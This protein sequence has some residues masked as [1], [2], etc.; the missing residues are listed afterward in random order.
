VNIS[1]KATNVGQQ[2]TVA[3]PGVENWEIEGVT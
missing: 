2:I 1:M 3:K